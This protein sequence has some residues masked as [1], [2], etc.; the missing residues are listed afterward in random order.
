MVCSIKGCELPLKQSGL[1]V[2][3]YHREYRAKAKAFDS[4]DFW[5]F[6]RKE[7]NLNAN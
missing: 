5:E 7:L 4:K 2:S 1:C 6:V 3:H